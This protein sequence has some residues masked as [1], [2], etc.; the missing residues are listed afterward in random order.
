MVKR[1]NSNAILITLHLEGEL[2]HALDGVKA[3][4]RGEPWSPVPDYGA[5]LRGVRWTERAI[6]AMPVSRQIQE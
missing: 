3:V 1:K 2:R 6:L 4:K 5:A